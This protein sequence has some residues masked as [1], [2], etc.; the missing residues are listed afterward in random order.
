MGRFRY[1]LG[2]NNL[3]VSCNQTPIIVQYIS[4]TIEI[5]SIEKA[6]PLHSWLFVNTLV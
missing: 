5:I 6:I 2:I 1:L 4:L 3:I